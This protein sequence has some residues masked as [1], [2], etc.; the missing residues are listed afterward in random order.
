MI[1][2]Y[3]LLPNQNRPLTPQKKHYEEAPKSEAKSQ[4]KYVNP[5]KYSTTLNDE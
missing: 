2:R 1:I 3:F 4:G 5:L